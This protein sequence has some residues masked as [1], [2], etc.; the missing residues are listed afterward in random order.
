MIDFFEHINKKID[1]RTYVGIG[2]VIIPSDVNREEFIQYCYLNETVS[3][4]PET[5]GLSYNNVKVSINCLNNLEFPEQDSFGSCVIYI[6]HPTQKVPI[7]IGILSKTDETLTL[8][9]KLFKLIKSLGNNSVSIIGDG[10]KGNLFINLNSEEEDG[11][12]IIIDVNSYTKN[13]KIK[14]NVRGDIFIISNNLDLKIKDKVSLTSKSIDIK[15]EKF[16]IESDEYK[17]TG[18]VV[19]FL[20]EGVEIGEN[21][22]YATLGETL[23]SDVLQPLIDALKTF[24]VITTAFGTPTTVVNPIT[25][26]KLELIEAK[27]N[28]ILASKLKIE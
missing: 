25:I 15:T 13:G 24:S 2:Y 28:N 4:Y 1:S 9:Y 14:I 20:N 17:Y 6:L 21:L 8:N 3:I 11:G 12:Q 5:G 7:I 23:K 16:N 10:K 26:A 22:Q 18:G 19:K 27:L